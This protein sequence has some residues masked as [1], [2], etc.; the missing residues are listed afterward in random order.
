[1]KLGR[2]LLD[3][4]KQDVI[5]MRE[6]GYTYNEIARVMG[7]SIKTVARVIIEADQEEHINAHGRKGM[8]NTMK[9]RNQIIRDVVERR[10]YTYNDLARLIGCSDTTLDRLL[11]NDPNTRLTIKQMKRICYICNNQFEEVFEDEPQ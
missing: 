11:D 3:G 2:K 4:K 7:C 10:N 6:N 5:T 1:M 8:R 9:I